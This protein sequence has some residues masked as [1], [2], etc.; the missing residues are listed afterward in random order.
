MNEPLLRT[1]QLLE[2]IQVDKY[3]NIL[4]RRKWWIIITTIAV[5]VATVVVAMRL[6]NFYRAQTVILVDPQKVPDSYVPSTGNM[7]VSDRLSTIRQEVMSPTR[8]KQVLE[9]SGLY[10]KQIGEGQEDAI[11]Q[12]LQKSI[13]LEVVDA[14]GSRSSA[15]Q[16]TFI[17]AT[18]EEAALVPNKLASMVIANN[19]Q[20][21]VE[22]SSDTA[23]F[24]ETELQKTKKELEEKESEM[25]RI[26][27]TYI[28]DLPESKQFHLEALT[29]LRNQ[30]QACQDRVA[31]D[32]QEKM[33]LQS[34]MGNTNSTV[35]LDADSASALSSPDEAQL[36]KMETHL[37]DLRGR[38]GASHPDVRKA[39]REIEQLKAKIATEQKETPAPVEAPRAAHHTNSNPVVT[40]QI[41]QLDQEIE[42]QTKLQKPL[43]VQIAFHSSK[44]EREPVFEQQMAGLM[45]D[46]DTLRGH[47]NHLLDKKL[48]ADMYTSL[49]THEQGERF[50]ILDPAV[51]PKQPFGPNR[52]IYGL[53]A[54]LGGLLGG[55]GLAFVMEM[56]DPSVRNEQEATDILGKGVVVG[57]PTIITPRRA[58]SMKIRAVGAVALTAVSA[59][60]FGL[61]ISYVLRRMA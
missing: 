33:I 61:A 16:I 42:E 46:Y 26:K 6:P 14:G 30:L 20:A 1:D 41:N 8:L 56:A 7:T 37:D 38:Y 2:D 25:G 57:I 43:E 48:S 59:G 44:L 22:H 17:G 55:A 34:S 47:Y 21:G 5:F 36:Q 53:V 4:R 52:F 18:P 51:V 13:Q 15:F 3:L 50:E 39:Q 32:Q 10:A 24:L 23:E 28:M 35:D 9:Q 27:S 31:R 19:V 60:V 45:R 12:K 11:I 58:R 54:L 40:A 49:V 29:T